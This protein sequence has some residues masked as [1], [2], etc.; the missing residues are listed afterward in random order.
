MGVLPR[1]R[2]PRPL[3]FREVTEPEWASY[4]DWPSWQQKLP[5]EVTEPE[6]A[7]YPDHRSIGG[8]EGR[9]AESKLAAPDV[10]FK[11]K[12]GQVGVDLPNRAVTTPND[13]SLIHSQLQGSQ[14]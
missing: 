7:S 11:K 4:P 12:S 9:L 10:W 14:R 6:W 13:R 3:R 8:G 5:S 2:R 1:H